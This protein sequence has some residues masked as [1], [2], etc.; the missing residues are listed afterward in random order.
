YPEGHTQFMVSKL[1]VKLRDLGH[2][3]DVANLGWVD[4]LRM[5]RVGGTSVPCAQASSGSTPAPLTQ[6][7]CRFFEYRGNQNFLVVNHPAGDLEILSYPS[8]KCLDVTGGTTASCAA[9]QTYAC[10]DGLNQRS[11]RE[12]TDRWTDPDT[13]AKYALYRF[14]I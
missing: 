1:A 11:R 12:L 7:P 2:L 5:A 3:F 10:H 4:Q 13:W 8:G 14:R 9:L 6:Q